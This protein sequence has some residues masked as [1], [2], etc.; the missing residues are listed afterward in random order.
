MGPNPRSQ[1]FAAL[2]DEIK[3]SEKDIIGKQVQAA[4]QVK[5]LSRLDTQEHG[6]KPG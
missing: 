6:Q 4:K 1:L 2:V 3:N 5:F